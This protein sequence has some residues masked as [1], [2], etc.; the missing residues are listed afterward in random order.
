MKISKEFRIGVLA[1]VCIAAAIWGYKFL[2]GKDLLSKTN[3]YYVKYDHVDQLRPSNSV[4]VNGFQVGTVF[5]ITLDEDHLDSVVVTLD[6]QKDIQVPKNT[7]ATIIS[8]GPLGGKA[9]VLQMEGPCCAE[10]GAF[11]RGRTFGLLKSMIPPDEVDLYFELLKRGVGSLVDTL[12]SSTDPDNPSDVSKSIEELKSTIHNLE[13]ITQSLSYILSQSSRDLR[14]TFDHLSSITGNLA[15]NNEQI[16]KTMS[17]IEMITTQ[18]KDADLGTSIANTTGKLEG[19]MEKMTSVMTKAEA[20]VSEINQLLEG[21]NRG[22][23]S[24]GLLAKND[25]LY[26]NL[27]KVS[28]NLDLF[29]QDFRL[30]PK[31]YVNVSVF[32]KKQKSY[33]LPTDDPAFSIDSIKN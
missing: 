31:R 22:E 6:I 26:V 2:N 20:T 9:V 21:V 12:T 10:D 19:T 25:E 23:G 4:Y 33:V 16:T 29:L 15:E 14:E 13:N 28:K 24:L 27:A 11:L 18:L 30:N 8:D 3:Y 1:I 17:N 7:I 32:G 5:E